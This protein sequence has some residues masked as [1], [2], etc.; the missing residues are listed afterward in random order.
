MT[1]GWL[2]RDAL[3]LLSPGRA[4]LGRAAGGDGSL[5]TKCCRASES[6]NN[7]LNGPQFL[8]MREGEPQVF[9][10]SPDKLA[11]GRGGTP[12]QHL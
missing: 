10:S 1:P 8:T 4:A 5:H 6:I 12:E 7:I 11:P 9:F 3:R 2:G